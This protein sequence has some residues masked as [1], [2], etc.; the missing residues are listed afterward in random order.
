LYA[1]KDSILCRCGFA[2]FADLLLDGA[3][4]HEDLGC[5][6]HR[7]LCE[8]G[9]VEAAVGGTGGGLDG[10]AGTTLEGDRAGADLRLA[11]TGLGADR[12]DATLLA[13]C[14]RDDV[15]SACVGEAAVFVA[16]HVHQ[17]PCFLGPDAAMADRLLLDGE[18]VR[19]AAQQL[20]CKIARHYEL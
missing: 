3:L 9:A 4:T 15:D 2:A 13:V 6:G 8:V 18:R 5:A 12:Q 11:E 16:V 1:N 7:D 14:V 17:V 10:L 20:P 19:S